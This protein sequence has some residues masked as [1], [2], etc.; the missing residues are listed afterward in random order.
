MKVEREK[1]V[2]YLP[3]IDEPIRVAHESSV[4]KFVPDETQFNG[5]DKLERY[6]LRKEVRKR[7]RV[8]AA[9][10]IEVRLMEDLLED[11]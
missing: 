10:H 4:L 8:M 7:K 2:N 9:C 3:V 5:E 1:L 11:E 6:N